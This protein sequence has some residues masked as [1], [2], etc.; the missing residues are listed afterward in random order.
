MASEGYRS[1]TGRPR[2]EWF[3]PRGWNFPRWL[4]A[5]GIVFFA[6]GDA[7]VIFM[8]AGET[9][10]FGLGFVDFLVA[11]FWVYLS[12]GDPSVIGLSNS[13]LTLK[14]WTG[15]QVTVPWYDVLAP[16]RPLAFF[17][18]LGNIRVHISNYRGRSIN[19]RT[20]EHATLA[21]N[22]VVA[23]LTCPYFRQPID[24]DIA[25][26]LGIAVQPAWTQYAQRA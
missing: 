26:E 6:W 9:S 25:T 22:Q 4:L 11:L 7:F 20:Y 21:K 24:P 23:I 1:D 18:T 16:D 17:G 2:A 13:G 12:T 5:I 10:L 14:Y 8:T 19:G 15:K 3:P